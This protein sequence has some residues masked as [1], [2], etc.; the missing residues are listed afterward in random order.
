M[1]KIE[2]LSPT[3]ELINDNGIK[4][5]G[6][7]NVNKNREIHYLVYKI[8]NLINGMY[9]YGQHKT[10]NPYDDYM[11]SGLMLENAKA[12][13]GIDNF[14]KTILFDFDTK[15]EMNQKEIELLPEIS[16][17]HS[18]P[19]CYNLAVGGKG[20]DLGPEVR[21]K[22]SEAISGEKN[23]MYGKKLS[24][25]SLKK[26]SD[27]LK[28]QP[29][30]NHGG[31]HHTDNAKRNISEKNIGKTH[32]E[33]SK[34][35]IRIARANQKN[36]TLDSAKGKHWYHDP[37]T[38]VEDMLFDKDVPACWIRGRISQQTKG[39]KY[40]TNGTI[41]ILVND[42]DEIPTGF[43]AGRKPI[44]S[45]YTI[46]RNKKISEKLKGRA[47]SLEHRKQISETLKGRHWFNNGV[48]EVQAKDCPVGWSKG[49]ILKEQ[50]K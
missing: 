31:W 37:I 27:K 8:T 47:V 36:L 32:T 17:Y 44:P 33:E 49:R 29:N 10:K 50:K 25:E 3:I 9:Y 40:Y 4:I 2:S 14:V 45:C 1:N 20:G 26:I 30:Y 7:S 6:L 16:C 19:M 41:D 21:K 22:I 43:V 13:Y 18:N 11:G 48:E 5:N 34:Q 46:E 35:K 38:N 39:R 23:G 15:I 24:K 12:K 42:G 28:G